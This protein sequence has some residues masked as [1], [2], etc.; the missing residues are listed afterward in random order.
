MEHPSPKRIV[1]SATLVPVRQRLPLGFPTERWARFDDEERA[2]FVHA[3]NVL[4]SL[5]RDNSLSVSALVRGTELRR[6]ELGAAV[7]LLQELSLVELG[8]SNGQTHVELVATPEDHIGVRFPDGQLR[9]V[10]VTRPVR[11]P[12]LDP[13]ELN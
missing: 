13:S 12:Q 2:H 3:Q 4:D 1:D 5:T 6:E 11:E 7:R 10:F 9:W 8:E